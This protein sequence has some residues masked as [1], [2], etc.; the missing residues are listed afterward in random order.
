M[1]AHA[2]EA[3]RTGI[4]KAGR[5]EQKI[6]GSQKA[7]P[8]KRQ[9]RYHSI[10]R[11]QGERETLPIETHKNSSKSHGSIQPVPALEKWVE[12]RWLDL[13]GGQMRYLK[14]GSGRSLILVHGLMGYS[15]SW[16]F[17]MPALAAHAT[18]Y[19]I[20]N[21]GA[22]L[23]TAPKGMD[24]SV[25][26]TADRLLQFADAVGIGEF[27]LLGT[28]HGG[29]V[30][31]MTGALS[32]ERRDARLKRLVL[33]APVNPW[34]RH[35]RRLAPFLATPLGTV[36]YN[37]TIERWRIFD[38][39]WLRRLFSHG[40]K[41]PPDSLA[42]YRIPVFENRVFRHAAHILANWTAD[43]K[44]LEMALPKTRDYPTLLMWGTKDRAVHFGSAEPLLRN[45]RNARLVA[46]EDVGHLPY[47]EASAD[48]NAALIEFLTS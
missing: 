30:A 47:E 11:K 8:L 37:N 9:R 5:S 17:A 41:I 40:S 42:G 24:C 36:V 34:S 35:G 1:A 38:Y 13:A 25:R 23:S 26:A 27:D 29:G 44:E 19:A 20:D 6:S 43:L 10:S 15:F 7:L 16:R 39:L 2:A 21:L 48:F 3:S 31:I 12:E 45:F 46:F 32:Q 14:A 33:V 4:K 22:G 28:S 18:V